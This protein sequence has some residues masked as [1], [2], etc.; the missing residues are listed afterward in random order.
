MIEPLSN[1]LHP[2]VML[3]SRLVGFYRAQ[4]ESPKFS[5]RYLMKLAETDLRTSIGRTLNYV[6]VH[7]GIS[8]DEYEK[9]TPALV[10]RKITYEEQPADQ[11]W[12]NSFAHEIKMIKNDT[13]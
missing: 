12:R 8:Y 7:S 11:V 13:L 2:K 1:C 3:I 5:I 9:L 4:L 6:A 10:K